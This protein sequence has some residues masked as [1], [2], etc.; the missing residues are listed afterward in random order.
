MLDKL[1]NDKNE[2]LRVDK[3]RSFFILLHLLCCFLHSALLKYSFFK[4]EYLNSPDS[5]YFPLVLCYLYRILFRII[6]NTLLAG[7][8]SFSTLP[9][10]FWHSCVL[11]SKKYVYGRDCSKLQL[12]SHLSFQVYRH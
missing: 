10:Y 7:N 1:Y 8:H 11:L 5:L 2:D 6:S 12:S 3:C 4:I 9:Q